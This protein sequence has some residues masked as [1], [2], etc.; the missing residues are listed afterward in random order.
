MT[1]AT[2]EQ[3]EAPENETP[4]GRARLGFALFGGPAAWA[5]HFAASYALTTLACTTGWGWLPAAIVALT[6]VLGGAA[7]V[8]LVLGWRGWRARGPPAWDTALTEPG[9]WLPFLY[10][11]AIMLAAV[12]LLTIVLEGSAAAMVPPCPP[13]HEQVST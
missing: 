13:V 6:A 5:L 7:A 2:G 10:T 3:H 12:S 4:R 8:A 1:G 9:G 11:G